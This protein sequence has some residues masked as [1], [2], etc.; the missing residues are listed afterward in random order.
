MILKL[1]KELNNPSARLARWLIIV[2]QFNFKI[3]FVLVKI[4]KDALLRFFIYGEDENIE[5]GI[6]LNNI[7]DNLILAKKR[8]IKTEK[9]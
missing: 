2:R 9:Y 4:V 5:Q 3:E 6:I 7:I 1:L 8:T